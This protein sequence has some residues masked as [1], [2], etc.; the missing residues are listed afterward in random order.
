MPQSNISVFISY[1]TE[2]YDIAKR[3]YDDLKQRGIVPWL[4]RENLL[5]GQNWRNEIPRVIREHDYFLLLISSH[6]VEKR[7]YIQKEQ[8]IALEIFDEIPTGDIFI[9][10]V[11][12]DETELRDEKLKNLHWTDL[13][14]YAYGFNQVLKVFGKHDPGLQKKQKSAKTWRWLLA[15]FSI[16][17]ISL[18]AYWHYYQPPQPELPTARI[19]KVPEAFPPLAGDKI[20]LSR[21][22]NTGNEKIVGRDK[23]LKLLDEIWEKGKINMVSLVAFGGVGKSFLVNHWLLRMSADNYRGAKRVYGWSFFSQGT[24]ENEK[25]VSADDFI[26]NALKWFGDPNPA[27]GSA[28]EKGLRLASLI[29]KERAL[30]ILDG[31]EPL[32]NPAGEV[33]DT[34]FKT[35]LKELAYENPGLC[36]VTTRVRLKDIEHLEADVSAN[37]PLP[38]EDGA[39]LCLRLDLENLSPEAGARL[40]E[41]LG[42]KGRPGELQNAAAEYKGHALALTLMGRFLATV[43]GGDIRKKDLI[44][45]L[46]KEPERGGQAARIMAFYE[47]LLKDTPKLN[48][49]YLMGLFDRPAAGEAMAALRKVPAITGLTDK[50]QAADEQWQ[51]AVKELRDLRLLAKKEDE[52]PDMLDCHPLVREYF[53]AKLKE[54]NPDAWKQ[55]HSRLYEYYKNLPEKQYPDTLEEMEPLFAAVSHGCMAGRHQEAL[56]D[57]YWERIR[58]KEDAYT[59]KKLGAF[60]SD[61]AAVSHFFEVLWTKPA[62]GLTDPAKA[63]ILNSAGFGLRALGRLREATQPIHA[64]MEASVKQEDW[65][66]AAQDA[67]NLSELWLTIG[68]VPQAVSYA[69]QSVKFADKSGDWQQNVAQRTALADALHQSSPFSKGG[70]RGIFGSNGNPPCPPLQKGGISPLSPDNASSKSPLEGGQRGVYEAL[71][72]FA[73]AEAMQKEE[74][75]EYPFLYSLRGFQYCDLLLTHGKYGEVLERAGKTLEWVTQQRILLDIALD[76]LSLGKARLLQTQE[77]GSKDFT[78]AEAY[79]HQAVD[80]LVKSGYQ[81]YVPLGLLTRAALYRVK[82]QFANAHADLDEAFEIADRSE[83]KLYITD[84]HLESCRLCLAENKPDRAK[85]HLAAAKKLIAQTGYHRRDKDAEELA[86]ALSEP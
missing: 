82:K 59:V 60:G 40:L 70:L 50:I 54:T 3:L 8:K 84:Y 2:D 74:Q 17:I 63:F 38:S 22:P 71:R 53:G 80:G 52:N 86:G 48:I 26:N 20:T 61:L 31:T 5:P 18:S 45:Q 39:E 21:L 28:Y 9:I 15:L 58:R 51:Y 29:R 33:R 25:Q 64:G 14:D 23:E 6:S 24:K 75:P 43:H 27:E 81:Y 47:N 36:I 62:Q 56:Y 49:L 85:E 1:A 79:L 19:I 41:H 4:D 10:P 37:A 13:S 83:M 76:H 32:Q 73:E 55:A 12:L 66:G 30:L 35:L 42:V 78:Q 46:M 11:R 68:D 77:Q 65:K 67:G 72:L 34:A 44:P 7:G 16:L 69:R 57:A